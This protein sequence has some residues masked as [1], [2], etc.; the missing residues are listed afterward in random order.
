M[1]RSF[2]KV[3]IITMLKTQ[4]FATRRSYSSET[5]VSASVRGCHVIPS[6]NIKNLLS[7]VSEERSGAAPGGA[8]K[9]REENGAWP[10]EETIVEIR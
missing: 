7:E 5:V 6:V 9:K 2:D 1:R 8:Y 3:C 10:E 4:M